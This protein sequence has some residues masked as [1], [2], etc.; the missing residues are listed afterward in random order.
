M[1]YLILEYEQ[2]ETQD[3]TFKDDGTHALKY[4]KSS[5]LSYVEKHGVYGKIYE[6]D[7]T[8]YGEYINGECDEVP[9]PMEIIEW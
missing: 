1:T 7:D 8:E 3:A 6:Y 5:A 9:E 4:T 2:D